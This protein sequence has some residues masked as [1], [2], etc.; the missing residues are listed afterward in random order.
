L[1]GGAVDEGFSIYELLVA[2]L[3]LSA[4]MGVAMKGM[5]DMQQRSTA[6]ASKTDAVQETR[7]FIDQVVRDMHDTGYPPPRV[8]SWGAGVTPQC[9]IVSG[10]VNTINAVVRN[11]TSVACGIISFSTTLVVYEGDLGDSATVPNVTD[12]LLNVQPTNGVSCP[13]VLRRGTLPKATWVL[14]NCDSNPSS[15]SC[16]PQYF[17]EVNGLLNSGNGAGGSTYGVSLG[18]PGSYTQ[19]STADVFDAYDTNGTLIT[20]CTLTTAISC[21][22]IRSLQISANVAPNF[23]D[24]TIHQY[25]VFS[26]TSKGRLNF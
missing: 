6:E 15:S 11:N 22:A 4:V 8:L 18:G 23:A 24:P 14:N 10:G 19:Y 16:T 20:S 3:V 13:C 21:S 26:I 12:V 5:M 1:N 25:P 17:T 7:D 2:I 9:V